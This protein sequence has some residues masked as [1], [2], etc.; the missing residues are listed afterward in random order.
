MEI[1]DSFEAMHGS[2]QDGLFYVE[3]S[4][5]ELQQRYDPHPNLP[6]N[7]D[8]LR[9]IFQ[10]SIVDYAIDTKIEDRSSVFLKS[11]RD[12]IVLT[13]MT[14]KRLYEYTDVK[15]FWLCL[16][17]ACYDQRHLLGSAFKGVSFEATYVQRMSKLSREKLCAN[18][19]G[20]VFGDT[21]ELRRKRKLA[22]EL[23]FRNAIQMPLRYVDVVYFKPNP[24]SD[25]IYVR[26]ATDDDD[27]LT[28]QY[29]VK[30][31]FDVL[32]L[33]ITEME[34]KTRLE[35]Y[36]TSYNVMHHRGYNNNDDDKS[37][38]LAIGTT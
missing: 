38:R 14:S 21:D 5:E 32:M 22:V 12:I 26:R 10:R 16:H 33:T 1:E 35:N 9:T 31:Q 4:G 17:H 11:F 28:I 20:M 13:K 24:L 30:A 2:S 36:C 3:D 19:L 15:A 29:I 7:M 25:V 6:L 8:V 37:T 18:L 34:T 23:T 27:P